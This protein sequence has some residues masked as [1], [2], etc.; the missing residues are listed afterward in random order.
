MTYTVSTARSFVRP[1]GLTLIE[2][3]RFQISLAQPAL[4]VPE[5]FGNLSEIA[6]EPEPPA[7]F[8]ELE[9]V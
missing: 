7:S 3:L 1:M 6:V 8:G 9:L 4:L 2:A 5:Y